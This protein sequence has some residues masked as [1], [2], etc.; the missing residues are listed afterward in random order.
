MNQNALSQSDSSIFTSAM[1]PEQLDEIVWFFAC[2]YKFMKIKSLLKIFGVA[3][4]K[5]SVA[6]LVTWL[7]NRLYFNN[8]LMEWTDFLHVDANSGKLKVTSMIIGIHSSCTCFSRMFPILCDRNHAPNQLLILLVRIQLDVIKDNCSS[9][10][11]P[12]PQKTTEVHSEAS[13]TSRMELFWK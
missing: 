11:F 10:F 3:W 9:Y 4:L 1:S 2:W 8:E 12:V 13:R 7:K 5:I 6:T